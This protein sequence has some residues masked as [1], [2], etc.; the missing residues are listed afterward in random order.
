MWN[1]LEPEAKILA[2]ADKLADMSYEKILNWIDMRYKIAYGNL[3]YKAQSKDDPTGL[4]L[5]T[6]SI[7][8]DQ[9]PEN[10]PKG[11]LAPAGSQLEGSNAYL[12]AFNKGN[13]KG[14]GD[15]KCHIC[16][17][18]GHFARDCPSVP[19]VSPASS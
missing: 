17:G 19:L 4:A 13:G 2:G 15:G 8:I 11:A 3:E 7:P 5:V 10:P 1:V 14:E 9:L 18:E 12:D 16:N 6:E